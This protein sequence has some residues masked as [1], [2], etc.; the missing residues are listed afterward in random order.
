MKK[1]KKGFYKKIRALPVGKPICGKVESRIKY[2]N[3]NYISWFDKKTVQIR[4]EKITQSW[5][6]FFGAPECSSGD[7]T[8]LLYNMEAVF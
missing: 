5:D 3:I 8:I 1:P 4:T 7:F 6:F 2:K